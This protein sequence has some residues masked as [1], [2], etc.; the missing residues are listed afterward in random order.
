M[1]LVV[2]FRTVVLIFTVVNWNTT[3]RPQYPPAFL[4][5]PLFIKGKIIRPGK[6]FLKF[7]D[8]AAETLCF[9]SPQ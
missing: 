1:S 6:S 7:D 9:N 2:I 5:C 8:T 4:R 3:F